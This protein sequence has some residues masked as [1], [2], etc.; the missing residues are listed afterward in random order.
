MHGS[1]YCSQPN[2]HKRLALTRT[3]AAV[4]AAPLQK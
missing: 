2:I 1:G 3:A 4:A